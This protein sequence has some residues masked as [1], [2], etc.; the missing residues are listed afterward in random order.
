ME[1]SALEAPAH[2]LLVVHRKHQLGPT[3]RGRRAA[4]LQFHAAVGIH[5]CDPDGFAYK[6]PSGRPLA[7]N[8][9][10]AG[11]VCGFR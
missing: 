3:W 8:S 11:P 2:R 7:Q 4:R 1:N 9:S 5:S 6:A 10:T